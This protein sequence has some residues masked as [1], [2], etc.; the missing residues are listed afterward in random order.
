MAT[1]TSDER[2]AWVVRLEQLAAPV[3][4]AGSERRLKRAMPVEAHPEATNRADVT[5][6]EAVGRLLAGIAPWLEADLA[7]SAAPGERALQERL[8]G[9][10]VA[11]LAS[12]V[13]PN[14]P[15]R[16]NFTDHHQPLV[17]AAFLGLG[18][19]R[20]PQ[21][22]ADAVDDVT[23]ERLIAALEATRAIQ[24]LFSN[25]ILFSALVEVAIGAIGGT[26]DPVRVDYGL[27]QCEQWYVGDGRYSDGPQLRDDYYNS[28]VIHPL[29]LEVAERTPDLALWYGQHHLE[30]LTERARR[31]TAVLERTI[32]P[33][34][35]FPPVGRSIAYRCGLFHLPARMA[36]HHQL[37]DSIAPGA[38]RSALGAVIERTLGPDGTFDD[39][40][41]L[42]IGLAGAQPGVG[43]TYISTGSLYLAAAA[44]LPL[45]LSPEDPFWS[46][47]TQPWT[48]AR[49]WA[50]ADLDCDR[51]LADRRRF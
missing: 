25:W 38:M 16:L 44:F 1:G 2:A 8:R 41:W 29:L 45:G 30:R 11:T 21:R 37:P 15:D 24:P 7:A 32:A 14:S 20:A 5:H 34:G 46:E 48:G 47:P 9:A 31:H 35:T 3:L 51:A 19:L 22:L 50:G 40:G 26:A 4:A 13:D 28:I 43:E 49:A 17:D 27:R 39:D 18:L 23:R 10:A 33:D 36:L 6:L 12:I 42:R